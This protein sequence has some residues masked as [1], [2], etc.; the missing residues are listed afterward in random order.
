MITISGIR[1]SHGSEIYFMD[2]TLESFTLILCFF[3]TSKSQKTNPPPNNIR[4]V[5]SPFKTIDT[6]LDT[7]IMTSTIYFTLQSMLIHEFV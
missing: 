7:K 5:T 1:F 4:M 2:L 6:K 3:A